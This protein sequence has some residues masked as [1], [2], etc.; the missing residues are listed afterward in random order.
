M[1][2]DAGEAAAIWVVVLALVAAAIV[3][4]LVGQVAAYVTVGLFAVGYAVWWLLA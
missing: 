4:S 3:C 2:D 1:I